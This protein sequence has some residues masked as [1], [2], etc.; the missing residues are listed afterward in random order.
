M[1]YGLMGG[2][3]DRHLEGKGKESE[4]GMDRNRDGHKERQDMD[5][6]RK[7]D[8]QTD[9]W[10]DKDAPLVQVLRAHASHMLA[11]QQLLSVRL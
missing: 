7:R 8:K 6:G 9:R 4:K 2:R 10:A 5:R 11:V 3:T 1:I